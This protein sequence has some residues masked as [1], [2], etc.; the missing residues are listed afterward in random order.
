MKQI[1]LFLVLFYHIQSF[2]QNNEQLKRID[3][4]VAIVNKEELNSAT[5]SSMNKI[6]EPT[7]ITS[8]YWLSYFYDSNKTVKKVV[9]TNNIVTIEEGKE[10][11]LNTQSVF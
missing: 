11:V 1:A 5:D 2:A 4:I 7:A 9:L 3:S 10:S 6:T 8:K